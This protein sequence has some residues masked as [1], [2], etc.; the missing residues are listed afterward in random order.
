MIDQF[1]D[2]M[3]IRCKNAQS[4][5]SESSASF[6]SA[7]PI[8]L[9]QLL[10]G[11][12]LA[13]PKK[14]LF[15]WLRLFGIGL[16]FCSAAPCQ[17]DG[18][19][20]KIRVVPDSSMV[21]IGGRPGN[22]SSVIGQLTIIS[23]IA[24][25][26][27]I[28]RASDFQ[29]DPDDPKNGNAETIPRAQIQVIPPTIAL[30][31]NT[32]QDLTI[33]FS[34]LKQAGNYSG[35][36]DFLVPQHG[37]ASS[38]HVPIKLHVEDTPK[39]LARKGS[40]GIKIQLVNCSWLGCWLGAKVDKS[41]GKENYSVPVDNASQLPFSIKSVAA[42]ATGELHHRSTDKAITIDLPSDQQ[43]KPVISFPFTISRGD[44]QPDH[45]MGDVQIR[46]PAA[47]SAFKIPLELNV[48]SALEM[49]LLAIFVGILLGRFIKYM[50]DKGTPQSDLL[51]QFLQMQARAAQ[52]PTDL[53]L[54][55]HMLQQTRSDIEQMR[56]DAVKTELPII[57]NRLTLLSRL[58]FLDALLRP[59][60]EDP[61]VAPILTNID[62][63]RNQISLGNDPSGIAETIESQVRAL[64]PAQSIANPAARAM[65]SASATSV[66]GSAK[67][68]A[69]KAAQQKP[70]RFRRT[71]AMIT[72]HPDALRADITLWFL[73]PLAWLV[74]IV[75]LTLTGFIQLYLKN[76]IFGADVVSDYFGLLV[77]ATGSDVAGR[78]L[79]N[80]KGGS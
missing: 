10:P 8:S 67:Y 22:D 45:Y 70:S 55:Q 28:F 74:L 24:A 47:D 54:L 25:S 76:P 31:A 52:D 42:S 14:R 3:I 34:G 9:N 61:G 43:A 35:S 29:Q 11:F 20:P 37:M 44:L 75:L 16:L 30:R 78:T 32:P 73:R 13:C 71:V 77:W 12:S 59:R 36:V 65:E 33:K 50:K 51:L 6:G 39:L 19:D 66:R 17:A 69:S 18:P 23:D 48:R 72:G 40:E 63:A 64:A 1:R 49:P 79:S 53:V 56:L 38:L 7:S 4:T 5:R 62:S 68:F 15:R 58:R 2:E 60:S 26:D 46:I 80:F 21:T 57:E 27:L 41:F